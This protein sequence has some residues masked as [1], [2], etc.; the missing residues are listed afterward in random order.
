MKGVD[1]SDEPTVFDNLMEQKHFGKCLIMFKLTVQE[2]LAE[3]V[4]EKENYWII[5]NIVE[6][7]S[8]RHP[9]HPEQLTLAGSPWS[10]LLAKDQECALYKNRVTAVFPLENEN[11]LQ[12]YIR[13]FSGIDI[14][15]P[16]INPPPSGGGNILDFSGR[17]TR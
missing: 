5:K 16:S 8:M 17:P 10:P 12:D 9:Q 1:M 4:E 14:P 2:I 11:M 13:N 7:L 3:V 6:I 15:T